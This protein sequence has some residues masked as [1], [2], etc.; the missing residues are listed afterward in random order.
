M[1]STHYLHTHIKKADWAVREIWPRHGWC[2]RR[3]LFA[4]YVS[5]HERG[6]LAVPFPFLVSTALFVATCALPNM[7][8]S[9]HL[10]SMMLIAYCMNELLISLSSPTLTTLRSGCRDCV[11]RRAR[12]SDTF[13]PNCLIATGLR[14]Q[15]HV[16]SSFAGGKVLR[17]HH[18]FYK[19][20][21]KRL[22]APN[23]SVGQK[24]SLR[25]TSDPNG[26]CTETWDP[27]S[28]C[29]YQTGRVRR[30]KRGCACWGGG[31]GD[32]SVKPCAQKIK[33]MRKTT[34][35]KKNAGISLPGLRLGSCFSWCGMLLRTGLVRHQLGSTFEGLAACQSARETIV[36][37]S[38]LL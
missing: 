32:E 23:M 3:V 33:S 38:R 11:A 8:M 12:K 27:L 6:L 31:R 24:R 4:L 37:C 22:V 5:T 18:A 15:R 14:W 25:K 13:S 21:R 26:A 2:G 16:A 1:R 36:V 35:R 10:T 29:A 7:S 19:R 9:T 20:V 28:G 34:K 17:R 30:A